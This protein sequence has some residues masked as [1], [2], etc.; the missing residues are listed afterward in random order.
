MSIV[1]WN[2]R[3][4]KNARGLSQMYS[5]QKAIRS[6]A[7]FQVEQTIEGDKST[8]TAEVDCKKEYE[9][10]RRTLVRDI[11]RPEGPDLYIENFEHVFTHQNC[12][13]PGC[14]RTF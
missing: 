4:G 13:W 12:G 8:Y 6:V 2:S 1:F 5:A 11:D 14:Y 10:V 7:L 3:W 9:H